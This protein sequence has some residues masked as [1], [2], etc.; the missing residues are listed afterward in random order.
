MKPPFFLFCNAKNKTWLLISRF[1]FV[2]S[3]QEGTKPIFG[4]DE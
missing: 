3:A 2:L 4:T 1:W